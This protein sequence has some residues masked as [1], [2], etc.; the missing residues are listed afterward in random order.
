MGFHPGDHFLGLEWLG[1]VVGTSQG[2]AF[3]LRLK[4]IQRGQEDNGAVRSLRIRLEALADFIAVHLRH[5]DIQENHFGL[6]AV[7]KVEGLFAFVGNEQPVTFVFQGLIEDFEVLRV[8]VHK[9]NRHLRVLADSF[10][11]KC[12]TG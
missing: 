8:I 6:M 5:H 12:R 11:H 2:E 4:I 10:S 1:D 9:Q 3:H 7:G